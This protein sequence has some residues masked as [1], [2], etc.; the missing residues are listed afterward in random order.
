MY[1]YPVVTRTQILMNGLGSFCLLEMADSSRVRGL[2]GM[3]LLE[4]LPTVH[5]RFCVCY[6]EGLAMHLDGHERKP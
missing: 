2:D 3:V 4:G 6:C 1:P 5:L